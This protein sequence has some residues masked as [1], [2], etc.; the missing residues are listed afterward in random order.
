MVW[1]QQEMSAWERNNRKQIACYTS[2]DSNTVPSESTDS[3][4]N[5]IG[6]GDV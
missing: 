6:I 3:H 5:N 4:M 1:S 2:D